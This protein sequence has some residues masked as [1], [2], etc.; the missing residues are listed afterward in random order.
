[1]ADDGVVERA[2][3][4]KH[5]RR[6][7][8]LND[9]DNDDDDDDVA[10]RVVRIFIPDHRVRIIRP[11]RIGQCR[12]RLFAIRERC[13]DAVVAFCPDAASL[14]CV[15]RDDAF[16]EDRGIKLAICNGGGGVPR[17]RPWIVHRCHPPRRR[18]GR[19]RRR[20]R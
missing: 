8:D 4:A 14:S 20:K 5:R 10:V 6:D 17:R 13:D 2:M 1:M 9:D 11:R 18:R 15:V 7:N 19:R 12:H 16:V 3:I